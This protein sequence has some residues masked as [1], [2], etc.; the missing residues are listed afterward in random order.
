MVELPYLDIL[1]QYICASDLPPGISHWD[2]VESHQTIL[3]IL[4]VEMFS[5]LVINLARDGLQPCAGGE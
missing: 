1:H 4:H 5:F 2:S 3:E